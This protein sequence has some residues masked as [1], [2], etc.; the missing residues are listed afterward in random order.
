MNKYIITTES[1]SDL[2]KEMIEYYDIRVIPMHVTMG[3]KTSPD[4]SF[5][6][7]KVFDFYDETGTL[8][9]T[10]GSTPQDCANVYRKVFD[11]YPEAHI[12]H[13]AYSEVT[14]VSYNSAT[15]AAE[16]FD[17]IHIVDSKHLTISAAVVVKATAQFIEDHPDAS[18]E[19][20]I[21]FV[22]EIRKRTH[23]VFMPKTLIYLKAGGRVSSLAY[24]GANLLKLC[25][26]IT[27]DNGYLVSG[28]KY[29]G[30]FKRCAKRM[31][32]DFFKNHD[33]DPETVMIG[34]ASGVDDHYK[35]VIFELLREH[36]IKT[37]EW[38]SAGAVI[39][40]HAGPAAIAIAGIAK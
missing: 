4:G 38:M 12:I 8:P 6:V 17:N 18:P 34:S 5:D 11:Q 10:S 1:G 19:M 24:H 9:K 40:S 20:I 13:V 27:L 3:D 36:G 15:I 7:G 16:D 28:K 39:S 2:P 22:E 26:T 14:T 30:S 33:I 29:R 32:N 25:P 21:S 31:I 37:S 23:M 35:E